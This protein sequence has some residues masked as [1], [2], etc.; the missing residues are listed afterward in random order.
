MSVWMNSTRSAEQRCPAELKAEATTSRTICSGS[1]DESA[2]SVFWPPVSAIS[3]TSGPS[4]S[5]SVRAIR[6]ATSVEPV[7]ATPAHSRCGDQRRADAA[8][9]RQEGQRVAGDAGAVQQLDGQRGDQRRLLGRL[10]DDGI[11]G[12]QGRGDLA[13]KDRQREIPR[14]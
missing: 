14:D 6:R 9:P 12:G 4:F 10:G 8:I 7:N 13:D 3:G 1:A 5:A 11:A 2:I